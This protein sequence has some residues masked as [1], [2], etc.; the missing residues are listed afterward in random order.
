MPSHY[1]QNTGGGKGCVYKLTDYDEVL[2]CL[3]ISKGTEYEEIP[4]A[5]LNVV[6]KFSNSFTSGRWIPCRPEHLSEEKVDELIETLPKSL[7]DALL[8]FQLEGVRFGLQRG[9]RCLIADEMGLGKTLQVIIK[10]SYKLFR[11]GNFCILVL[12]KKVRI[13]NICIFGFLEK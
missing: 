9:G 5:T 13:K 12:I 3:K 4:W 8:P 11:Y 6:N 7:V 10:I 2:R 1:T